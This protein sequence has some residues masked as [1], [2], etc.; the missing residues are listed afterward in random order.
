MS[1][2]DGPGDT[3]SP[4]EGLD[5]DEVR[6]DDGDEVVD[7]PEGWSGADRFGTTQRE[8]QEGESLDQRLAEEEPDVAPPEPLERPVAA[9]PDD[10]L[11]EDIVDEVYD[12][13]GD[14]AV[15]DGG[16]DTAVVDGGRKHAELV[17]GV[18]VED[19]RV[20]RGQIGGSPEDGESLFP[21]VE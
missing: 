21:V 9:M 10:E 20:D 17:E 14:T 18:I 2:E 16:G 13:G 6:N 7:P 5:S 3:L 15:Y 11:T 12:G 8:E 19:S 4:S 1:I